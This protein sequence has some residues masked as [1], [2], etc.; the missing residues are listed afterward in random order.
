MTEISQSATIQI[1]PAKDLNLN[2]HQV[3]KVGVI[4]NRSEYSVS[5]RP[6]T[7]RISKGRESKLRG[8]FKNKV[9]LWFGSGELEYKAIVAIFKSMY[10]L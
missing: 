1:Y 5:E 4:N 3:Q 10:M 6:L 2:S 7:F 8:E 9:F